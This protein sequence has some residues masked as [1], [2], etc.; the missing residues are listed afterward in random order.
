MR[1]LALI[2]AALI[3]PP[4]LAINKCIVDGKVTYS[5]LPCPSSAKVENVQAPPPADMTEAVKARVRTIEDKQ[6][7]RR[8]DNERIERRWAQDQAQAREDREAKARCNQI[9]D[10]KQEAEYWRSE[11]KHPDNVRREAAKADFYNDRE[12]FEC[13]GHVNGNQ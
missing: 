9:R 7:L 3:C 12:F 10:K 8:K 4:A 2:L 5:D 11:F 13:Y 6:A 1:W